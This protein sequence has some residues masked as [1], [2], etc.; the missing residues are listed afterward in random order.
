MEKESGI[1]RLRRIV[2]WAD[3]QDEFYF[4]DLDVTEILVL[5]NEVTG[6]QDTDLIE[7]M[8]NPKFDEWLRSI[9]L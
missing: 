6:R 7:D 1:D 5:F 3:W 9:K 2:K 4:D 8:K